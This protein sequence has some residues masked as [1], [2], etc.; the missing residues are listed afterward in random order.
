MLGNL[1][2]SVALNKTNVWVCC[3]KTVFLPSECEE[4][5]PGRIYRKTPPQL[6]R[7][8]DT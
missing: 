3:C 7:H 4:G 1:T 6:Y 2:S 5:Q 8:V